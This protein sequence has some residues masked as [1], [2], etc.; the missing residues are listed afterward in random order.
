MLREGFPTYE[1]QICAVEQALDK[2]I[3]NDFETK[4]AKD[5]VR[6]YGP[7]YRFITSLTERQLSLL[8]SMWRKVNEHGK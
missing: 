6:K 8:T 7:S 5:M 1:E 3:L 2:G 4:V